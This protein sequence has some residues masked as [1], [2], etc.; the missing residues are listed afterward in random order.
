LRS[1]DLI[2]LKDFEQI[3]AVEY[4]AEPP[5][6]PAVS[7]LMLAYNHEPFISE[8]IQNVLS[9]ECDQHYEI[10]IGEDC[11]SDK[12]L[13]ICLGW[14]RRYPDKIRVISSSE[15]VGMHRNFARIWSRARAPYIACCEGDDYWIDSSKL[16][17]QLAWFDSHPNGSLC[18]TD[19]E[20]LISTGSGGW[21]TDGLAM[22]S[23]T[24]KYYSLEDILRRY[25]FHFSTVMVCKNKIHFPRWFW[26]AYCVDRPL[27]LLA[28]QSGTV[29][30]VDGITSRYRQHEGGA[31]SHK[32][33]LEKSAASRAL[34]TQF[35]SHLSPEFGSVLKGAVS[36]VIWSYMAEA[37]QA[38]DWTAAR[39]LFWQSILH[40]NG[41][42]LF[43]NPRNVVV[44]YFRIY[45][46]SFYRLIRREAV[47]ATRA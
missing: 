6:C 23:V 29:G 35:G 15:N 37:V 31:W 43:R 9:Q 28:A 39:R 3:P 14:M 18:G 8:A 7:I 11:S 19:C 26:D 25:T 45:F 22:K 30:C 33:P 13:E 32:P 40:N 5:V 12:T 1:T 36:G 38:E 2:C 16:A 4:S 44:A 24:Q 42:A 21:K 27:Y 10:I 41:R 47:S 17:R 20:R 46:P 34:F